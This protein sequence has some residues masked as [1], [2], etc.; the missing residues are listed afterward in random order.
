MSNPSGWSSEMGNRDTPTDDR[1]GMGLRGGEMKTRRQLP[2][3][4]ARI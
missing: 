2:H 4:S 1:G 3:I